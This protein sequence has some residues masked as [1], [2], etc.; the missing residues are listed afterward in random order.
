MARISWTRFSV[1]ASGLIGF[2]YLLMKATVPTEEQ[3]YN[4]MAPDL[5]RKVDASRAARLARE[6]AARLPV[7]EALN[8]DP[9][10]AKPRWANSNPK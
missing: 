10:T 5:R 9:D 8:T 4:A 1:A 2:G 3:T 7:N 6:E